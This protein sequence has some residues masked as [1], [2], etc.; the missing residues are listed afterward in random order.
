MKVKFQR[1]D[2]GIALIMVLIV[3][4]VLGLMAGIFASAMKVET[5]LARNA[6]FDSELEWMGR[7]GI[8]LARYI[9]GQGA[10]GPSAQYD[11][12]NQKWAGGLGD[13][14]SAVSE[15]PMENFA[16][17]NGTIS[18]K[19][20][21]LDRKFNINV[22]DEVIL[23]QAL[24]LIG[25]DAAAS[26]SIIDSILDWRDIDPN[27]HLSGTE[28]DDY[29]SSPNPGFPPYIAKDG[30]V[31]DLSEL[32]MVRGVTPNMYWGSS[33]GGRTPLIRRAAAGGQSAFDEPSYL[34]GLVDLFTPLSSRLININTASATT[35]QVIPWIDDNVAQSI[36]SGPTGRAGPDGADGTEDDVPFRSVSDLGRVSGM[37]PAAIQQLGTYFT[38]RSLVFEA[39]VEARIGNFHRT[40]IA[41]LRRNNPRDIQVQNMYWE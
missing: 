25:V 26:S 37:N 27:T 38:V 41:V 5:T 4:V 34:V 9:L 19:I 7:S 2:S 6:S 15:I 30:P 3:I 21:D 39:R 11:S 12:L 23:R 1:S 29:R 18:L 16:L 31:D 22:A 28:S 8:E 36:I 17:G 33:G 40:F 20:V 32:L 13:T 10:T 14:N 24:T 35:L